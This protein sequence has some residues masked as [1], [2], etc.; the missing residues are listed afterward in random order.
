MSMIEALWTFS[1]AILGLIR[2]IC[3]ENVQ[4]SYLSKTSAHK[5]WV[6]LDSN[7]W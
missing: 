2:L 6:E 7:E 1:N 4:S 5:D 3:G